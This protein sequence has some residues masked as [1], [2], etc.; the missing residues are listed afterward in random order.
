MI[1]PSRKIAVPAPVPRVRTISTPRPLIAPKP[2]TSASLST[3]TGLPQCWASADCRSNP[4]NTSRAKIGRSQHAPVAHIAGKADRYPFEGRRVAL[5]ALSMAPTSA[6]GATGLGGVG[7]RCRLPIMLPSV[8][9]RAALIP[10]PPISIA[11]VRGWFMCFIPCRIGPNQ[12][13]AGTGLLS[14]PIAG[15]RLVVPSSWPHLVVL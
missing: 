11:S 12:D 13:S 4:A 2:C 5:A 15:A 3:R 6:S 8:S 1:S 9:S 14:L 10:L 7:T